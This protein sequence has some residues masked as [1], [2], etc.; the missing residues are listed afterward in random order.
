MVL[1]LRPVLYLNGLLLVV[2]GAAMT[3]PILIDLY[4]AN[5]DWQ[6]FLAAAVVTEFIGVALILTN[7]GSTERLALRQG[8]ILTASVWVILP[9]FG[10]LPITFSELNASYTDAFFEAMS[11][12]T[13]TGS[14]VLTGLDT[15]PPGLLMWRA[16]LHWLGG[17][18]IVVMALSVLPALQVAGYQLFQTESSDKSEKIVPRVAQLVGIIAAVYGGL[19]LLCIVSY[20]LVGMTAFEAVAHAFATVSTGGFATSD[21]SIGNFQSA[22]V[23]AV[24]TVFMFLSAVPFILYYR[25]VRGDLQALWRDNQVQLLTALALGLTLLVAFWLW[26]MKGFS[27]ADALRYSAFNVISVM[28]GTG[29]ANVDYQLWGS[30]AVGLFFFIGFLG[31][32]AGSSAGGIKMFRFWILFSMIRAQ[33]HRLLQPNVVF[34]P[35]YNQRRVAADTVGSVMSFLFLFMICFL[36]LT[37]A[38]M[39]TGLDIITAVTGAATALANLG[40]G[41]GEIIGPAGN[42]QPLPDAAKWLLSLGMMLGRLELFTV[43]VLLTPGFWRA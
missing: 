43:L 22:S 39:A 32:C 16:I 24:V 28:T 41:L 19:T 10:A 25:A 21:N 4:Y 18:G 12:L 5:P 30:F 37:V 6:V 34:F 40:P 15:A 7:R 23:D 20:L 26:F 3:V 35:R 9:A 2:L 17:V 42:F 31:G 33:L 36:A 29:F 14:T 13:T 38:L 8:F 1:D 27:L 11:G